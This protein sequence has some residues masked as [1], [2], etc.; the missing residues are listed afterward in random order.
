MLFRKAN[1]LERTLIIVKPDGVQRGLTGEINQ[2]ALSNVA[3][4]I[5]GMKFMQVSQEL[6]RKHYEI[7][8]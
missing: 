4:V 5:V 3:C 6:V 1:L 7:S 8:P 2:N